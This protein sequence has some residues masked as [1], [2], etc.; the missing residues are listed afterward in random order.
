MNGCDRFSHRAIF[1]GRDIHVVAGGFV[2]ART[3]LWS[4]FGPSAELAVARTP[5]F[6]DTPIYAWIN[7]DNATVIYLRD[8]ALTQFLLKVESFQ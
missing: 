2:K 5:Y 3:W 1:K 6:N 7:D 4:T 8:E